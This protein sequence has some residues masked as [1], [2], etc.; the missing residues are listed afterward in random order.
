MTDHLHRDLLE[1]RQQWVDA[2][3]YWQAVAG[4]TADLER[5]IDAYTRADMLR[6]AIAELDL[7]LRRNHVTMETP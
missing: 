7:V 4:N 2:A 6:A 1:L 5:R 3:A